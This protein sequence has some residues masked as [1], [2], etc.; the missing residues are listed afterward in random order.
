VVSYIGSA[1]RAW[2][3]PFAVVLVF[4]IDSQRRITVRTPFGICRSHNVLV[5]Y[6]AAG[7]YQAKLQLHQTGNDA[8]GTFYQ[9][10]PLTVS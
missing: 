2:T 3:W 8:G 6:A 1:A 10:Y 9:K 7:S 5:T 4:T